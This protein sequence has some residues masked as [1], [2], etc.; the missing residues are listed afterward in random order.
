MPN[1]ELY[2]R[3]IVVQ[4]ELFKIQLFKQN[5]YRSPTLVILRHLSVIFYENLAVMHV[6]RMSKFMLKN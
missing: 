2:L 3:L 4:F 6:N 1:F 5:H